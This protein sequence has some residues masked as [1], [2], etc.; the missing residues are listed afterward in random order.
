[1]DIQKE[2]EILEYQPIVFFKG[3]ELA[4]L[5]KEVVKFETNK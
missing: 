1:M 2:I 5:Y 3:A 4:N